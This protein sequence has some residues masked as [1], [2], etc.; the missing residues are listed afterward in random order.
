MGC[1]ISRFK[2]LLLKDKVLLRTSSLWMICW[3]IS[4]LLNLRVDS[5]AYFFYVYISPIVALVL[6]IR[7]IVV[8]IRRNDSNA[9]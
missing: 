4:S 1:F 2:Y 6:V 8:L 9:E 5:I 7:I 3:I